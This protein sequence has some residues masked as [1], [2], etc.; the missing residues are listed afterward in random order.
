M[1]NLISKTE[2]IIKDK[3]NKSQALIPGRIKKLQYPGNVYSIAATHG[4]TVGTRG[5]F[6]RSEYE[7]GEIA[8]V[9]DIEAYARQAFNK[10]TEQCLKE[11]YKIVSPNGEAA[12]YVRG[13]L[14]EIGEASGRTFDSLLRGI[15]TNIVSFS[16]CFVVKKRDR[17]ASS[18][19]ARKGP[20]G[21]TIE[22][23]AGYFIL[24]P[25]SIQIK[26]NIHGTVKKYK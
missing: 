22:P 4:Y 20:T 14:H 9:M 1:F 26:R 25:T 5:V 12:T 19:N 8:K 16:N 21:E 7:L 23:V 11:G 13:R 2:S 18:G 10:H 15:V 6:Q 24:D 17:R 3:P